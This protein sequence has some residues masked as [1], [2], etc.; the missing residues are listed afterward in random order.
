MKKFKSA[1]SF[2]TA[3]VMVFAMIPGAMAAVDTG[4]YANGN[5]DGRL[6]TADM[7]I[8]YGDGETMN[9]ASF[10]GDG[11]HYSVAETMHYS[12]DL[13]NNTDSETL[14]VGTGYNNNQ[15]TGYV[16]ETTGTVTLT[17]DNNI[18][19]FE[20]PAAQT[21]KRLEMWVWPLG[22]IK[23]YEIQYFDGTVWKK[24]TEGSLDQTQYIS[25]NSTT[26]ATAAQLNELKSSTAYIM[27]FDA[28]TTSKLRFV[29][30]SFKD[31]VTSAKIAEAVPRSNHN[32]NLLAEHTLSIN[33]TAQGWLDHIGWTSS[34]GSGNAGTNRFSNPYVNDFSNSMA[35]GGS[36]Y[37][38]NWVY[39]SA[40][41]ASK[42]N[43]WPA[44]AYNGTSGITVGPSSAANPRFAYSLR[45]TN[46]PQKISKVVF[47]LSQLEGTVKEFQIWYNNTDIALS[48]GGGMRTSTL[49]ESA[50]S[51]WELAATVSG[52]FEKGS[53]T[54]VYLPEGEAA[55]YWM[56]KVT[57]WEGTPTMNCPEFYV[58]PDE[59]LPQGN[60]GFAAKHIFDDI[61][62]AENS[63]S[64][65]ISDKFT[66]NG[67]VYDVKWESDSEYLDLESGDIAPHDAAE[68]ITLKAAISDGAKSYVVEKA[69]TLPA[70]ENALK[71]T[72]FNAV[73]TTTGIF[74]EGTDES[75]LTD[76]YYYV[77]YD[78][79]LLKK[80]N[81]SVTIADN[82]N[83]FAKL[84]GENSGIKW[85]WSVK[86]TTKRLDMWLAGAG[87]IKDYEIQKSNNG[88]TWEKVQ[89]GEF[90]QASD[91]YAYYY[92][93]VLDEP[94]T[95]K[96]LRI[97]AKSF[98]GDAKTAYISETIVRDTNDIN[99][100]QDSLIGKQADNVQYWSYSPYL[101]GFNA[102]DTTSGSCLNGYTY[103]YPVYSAGGSAGSVKAD[104]N[105]LWYATSFGSSKVKVN[106]FGV[107]V[108]AGTIT[109]LEVYVANGTALHGTAKPTCPLEYSGTKNNYE[110]V[111]V[112]DCNL[113]SASTELFEIPNAIA[114]NG[115]L[116]K[117]V[118]TSDATISRYQFYS[119][120]DYE[121][122][123]V[124]APTNEKIEGTVAAGE[125][126]TFSVFSRNY[127]APNAKVYF[128][129]YEDNAITDI[130]VVPCA[131][132]GVKTQT[133]TYTIPA[134]ANGALKVIA[135]LW[136]GITLVP[137]IENPVVV[138]SVSE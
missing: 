132:S 41:T 25:V 6:I 2:L 42:P 23:T 137:Y 106:K 68:E 29:A 102:S 91:T 21:V 20:W 31:G 16:E 116:V 93:I 99:L 97:V 37:I 55:E 82:V 90:A 124:L 39:Q 5:N 94:V 3:L 84:E 64:I 133:A 70:F 134:G 122:E 108:S 46:S 135:Y 35:Y 58:I 62:V 71:T 114:G 69:F 67:T 138:T 56:I 34:N 78:Y 4:R 92:P 44:Y 60:G 83:R 54:E 79:D 95:A 76:K 61:A 36:S 119:V 51:N 18:I 121:L 100:G 32:V 89:S 38:N 8:T 120:G 104:E 40:N 80:N 117:A 115:I 103:I 10:L 130:T 66:Y 128:A 43:F 48:L 127:N 24:H 118:G 19:E 107:K 101:V 131:L 88:T 72:A 50:T 74:A 65:N 22:A 77:A 33:G 87:G 111:A 129:L 81:P 75:I 98:Y 53:S 49:D 28:V 15:A 52:T 59:E 14:Q 1:L 113:T 85:S 86:T 96:N 30:T 63:A 13:N 123:S 125:K 112:I 17:N 136:D 11:F 105:G 9:D 7:T 73:G 110:L 126:L 12:L 57:K 27:T 26:G 109:K 47:N 45:F